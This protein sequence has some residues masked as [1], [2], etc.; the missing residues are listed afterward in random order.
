MH[1]IVRNYACL[2]PKPQA[3]TL[4]TRV[5]LKTKASCLMSKHE[6]L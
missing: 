5:V 2:L 6:A 3:F 1:L 4:K